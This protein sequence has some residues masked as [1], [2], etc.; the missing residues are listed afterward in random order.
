[1]CSLLMLLNVYRI[2]VVCGDDYM[3][4]GVLVLSSKL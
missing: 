4:C 2:M 3:E 1:M